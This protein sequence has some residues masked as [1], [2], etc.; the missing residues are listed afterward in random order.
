M[1]AILAEFLR[2]HPAYNHRAVEE[3]R[4]EEYPLLDR[5]TQAYL[6]PIRKALRAGDFSDFGFWGAVCGALQRRSGRR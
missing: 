2:K 6:D 3:L 5:E 1:D 4:A